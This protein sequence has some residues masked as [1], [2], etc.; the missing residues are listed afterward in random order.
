MKYYIYLTAFTLED[1][2]QVYIQFFFYERYNTELKKT[3]IVNG[4]FMILISFKSMLDL[5][6]YTLEDDVGSHK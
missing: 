4:V 6:K 3:T 2:G 1:C 5:A